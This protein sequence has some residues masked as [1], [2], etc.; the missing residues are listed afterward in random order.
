MEDLEQ[1][2]NDNGTYTSPKN[3]KTYKSL[4]AFRSHWYYAFT[5]D[6]Q[7]FAKRSWKEK[8]SHCGEEYGCANIRKHE[9]TCYLNPENIT[10]CKE[11][12]GPIK[13]YKH[14]KGTCS[15]Q[16]SNKY[17]AHERCEITN[18]RTICFRYHKKKC[19]VCGEDKIVGV[20][21]NDSNHE[22][23]DPKN[24]IPMCPT[25]HQY[26]HSR[27]KDEVQPIIDKFVEHF[28]RD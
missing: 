18:Y 11:C 14:N 13:N 21:H 22:N 23:N 6:P 19:I 28:I 16:C 4:K 1:Y 20:H 10:L 12:N 24:L 9:S 15:K 5:T 25:H 8:C 26:V 3:N 17:Y 7:A 2:K 27:Y